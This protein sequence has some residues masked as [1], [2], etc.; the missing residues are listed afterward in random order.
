MEKPLCQ[1]LVFPVFL[2]CAIGVIE[3]Q[4]IEVEVPRGWAPAE[5]ETVC[6]VPIGSLEVTHRSWDLNRERENL[7]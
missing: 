5:P 6:H 2:L 3:N 1:A 7:Y 4:L